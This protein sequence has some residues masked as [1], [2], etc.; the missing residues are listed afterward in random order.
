MNFRNKRLQILIVEDNS[1]D[2]LLIEEY[3]QEELDSS[4]IHR[5]RTFAEAKN[6][7]TEENI[8]DIIFLDLSLP[9]ARGE[10]LVNDMV[11]LAGSIPVVVLTGYHDKEFGIR[12]LSLGISDYL[13]K[14]ELNA[15]QL[16]RSMTYAIERGRIHTELKESEEN[17]R[18]LFQSSPIPMWVIDN[19]S[20][21]FLDVNDSAIK[22]FGY[23]R[24]EFLALRID[25]T[26]P[27][28]EQSK[29]GV[30]LNPYRTNKT[31]FQ[32]ILRF[33]KKNGEVFTAEIVSNSIDFDGKPARLTQ[34]TDITEKLKSEQAL[35][36]SEQRFRALVQEGS[37]L[38]D[39]LNLNGVYKYVSPTASSIL[40]MTPGQLIGKDFFDY[41]NEEDRRRVQDQ[42]KLLNTQKR[43]HILP[44]RY[45]NGDNKWRW[46]ETI[47][48]NLSDDPAIE[49]IVANSRDVTEGIENEIKLKD[50]VDRYN[51]V[52]K[53]TSDI[54]WD[55]D[56]TTDKITW[57][58]GLQGIFGYRE[59]DTVTDVD[60]WYSKV[61]PDDKGRVS[62][63]INFNFNKKN[64]RWQDEYRFQ[65][66]DGSYKYVFDRVF[67]E[68]DEFRNP[69]RMIGAMQ[70]IT[71]QKEEEQRLKLL[72]SVITNTNDAVV[73][74]EAETSVPGGRK[75]VFVNDAFC[76][77]TG[78]SI[79]ETIGKALSTLHGDKT[80]D[81]SLNQLRKHQENWEPCEIELI[82]YK[83][84]GEYFWL[85]MDISPVSDGKGWYSHWIAILRDVSERMNYIKA[86]EEQNTKL[87]DIAWTQSHIVRAPLARIIGFVDLLNDN[88]LPGDFN[89]NEFIEHIKSSAYELD[90]II[91]NI[92][93]KTEQVENQPKNNEP[94]NS[95]SR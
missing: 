77:M 5:A 67:L 90:D 14:D 65:C 64:T 18:N 35:K 60:W 29:F 81:S 87:R 89:R 36:T 84:N 13:L 2:F 7:L 8:I 76:K 26:W 51:I 24:D 71:K 33:N 46:I 80:N 10:S 27:E 83:K 48:T 28:E 55:R 85:N 57:N 19:E 61:H 70:D 21:F 88:N 45:K 58:R 63:I 3:L 23:S 41:V 20:L 42:F 9:D 91:R 66:A 17:Y 79:E 95:S 68:I 74:T 30:L 78:Y 22:H 32:G 38:I 40:G 25:E 15:S 43:L 92:V 37:D 6:I 49:G 34:A 52:A 11:Q 53:A 12:T 1:G 75:I 86:I 72:E 47:L 62:G 16:F 56:F 93:K 4:I 69:V 31:L 94:R 59:M 39:I 54:I 73:I 44:F 50:S 82:C